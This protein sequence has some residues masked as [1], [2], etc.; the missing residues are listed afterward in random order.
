MVFLVISDLLLLLSLEIVQVIMMV[1]LEQ[2]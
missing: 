1:E 2:E